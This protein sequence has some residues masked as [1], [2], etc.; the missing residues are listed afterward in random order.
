MKR[1]SVRLAQRV[2]DVGDPTRSQHLAHAFHLFARDM[3]KVGELMLSDG[4]W[5]GRQ[6]VPADWVHAITTQVTSP[7]EMH[8]AHAAQRG[9]GYGMM[10]CVPRG[11][12]GSPLQGSSMAWGLFGQWILVMPRSGLVVVEKYEVSAPLTARIPTVPVS[13]FLQEA[14]GIAAAGC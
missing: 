3:A 7:A 13:D 10:W 12:E 14:A 6:L 9:V 1:P 11:G 2:N 5:N 8:P 4:R